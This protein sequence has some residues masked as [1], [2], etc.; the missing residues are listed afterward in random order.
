MTSEVDSTIQDDHQPF[1]V[2]EVSGFLFLEVQ[3]DLLLRRFPGNDR[4][5]F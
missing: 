4:S 1:E 3:K 5:P 2:S